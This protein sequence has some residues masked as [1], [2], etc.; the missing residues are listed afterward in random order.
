MTNT[1]LL[2][3]FDLNQVRRG[4]LRTSIDTRQIRIN[5]FMR[6]LVDDEAILTA[7]ASAIETFLDGRNIGSRTRYCW[8]SHLHAFYVW[9][10]NEGL[11]SLDPTARII[12]PRMRR[13]LPRPALTPDLVR[14]LEAGN[15]QQRCWVLLAAF[16]GLRCQEIAGLRREDVLELE[17]ILRVVHGKGGVE[18][19]MGLNPQVLAA[20]QDLPMPRM[21]WLFKR[22]KGGPYTPTEVS[23]EFNAFL[24]DIG[25]NAV[26][27]QLRHWFGTHLYAK[28]RDLRLV[29]ESMGHQSPTTTT[30][31]VAFD[32]RLANEAIAD[33]DFG[34][35]S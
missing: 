8:L 35:A 4:N 32:R 20:L 17:G 19:I 26:A 30:I 6:W 16:Q 31:Y 5:A 10:T 18:R 3:S 14:A 9:A 34:E 7:S 23:V 28:T 29:Q 13:S 21:G 25:V 2:A 11:C 12:R 24:R 33:L 1:Q 22:P 27:H 15:A